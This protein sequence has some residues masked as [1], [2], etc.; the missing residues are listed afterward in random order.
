M[1]IVHRLHFHFRINGRPA[2]EGHVRR[3]HE[4][5]V[6]RTSRTAVH[7]FNMYLKSTVYFR[8]GGLPRGFKG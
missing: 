4:G 8:S 1:C 5:K 6:T 2:E 7:G 3:S